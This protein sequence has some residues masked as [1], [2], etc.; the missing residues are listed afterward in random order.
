MKS[1][2]LMSFLIL[3]RIWTRTVAM[4]IIVAAKDGL[5]RQTILNEGVYLVNGTF[6]KGFPS[7][8]A[9]ARIFGFPENIV[10]TIFN[11]LSNNSIKINV[12]EYFTRVVHKKRGL[13]QGD[14]ISPV[15]YNLAFDPF[16]RSVLEDELMKGYT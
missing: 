3:T 8:P 14:P 10:I 11:S 16:L 9:D 4:K 12:N 5:G 7:Y 1:S 15:L 13:K 6:I 2:R